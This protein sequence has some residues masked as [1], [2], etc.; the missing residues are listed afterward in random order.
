MLTADYFD[1]R[2]SR[3]HAATLQVS[4]GS[5]WLEGA[6][7]RRVEALAALDVSE[8]MGGAPR[9]IRFA[10]GAFC[11]VRDVA[12]LAALLAAAGIG[13]S[14][15]VRAQARWHWALGAL[16][17]MVAI[18]AATYVWA[19]PWLARTLAPAVP[20]AFVRT[21]SAAA[22][23]SL[24]A[25]LLA[26]SKV[27][28]TRQQAIAARVA[29]IDTGPVALPPH[30]LLFRAAP[31]V[32]PNALALPSGDIVILDELVTVASDEELAAVVAHELGHVSHHHGMQQL[33]QGAVVAFVVGAYFGDVS[34]AA[35]SL[36]ALILE[37]RYSRE[38]EREADAYAGRALI[39]AGG[40]VEP[41]IQVLGRIEAAQ[42]RRHASGSGEERGMTA[43]FDS[44][45]DTAARVAALR[46]MAGR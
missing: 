34:S 2:S 4:G 35:A 1:G 15:L 28:A 31:A 45:P 26:P 9:T 41:L 14:A 37:S 16:T 27:P 3:R 8:P 5:L 43:I 29:A 10:D 38:F 17:A 30:R 18:V 19:L 23:G 39:A 46:A 36:G 12:G 6:F 21:L 40:S 24:D 22:L 44:H 13:D 7:G 11:E 32:G 33:I 42:A 25:H 20:D